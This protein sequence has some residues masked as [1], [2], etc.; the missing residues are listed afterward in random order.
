MKQRTFFVH[1]IGVLL[2]VAFPKIC[3]NQGSGARFSI[4]IST[5]ETNVQS[6]AKVPLNVKLTNTSDREFRI[7]TSIG[8]RAER[9][10]Q[11][12]VIDDHGH[13]A[14]RTAYGD[15]IDGK[16]GLFSGSRGSHL[17]KPGDSLVEN[18][19][20]S[21]IFDPMKPGNYMVRATRTDQLNA[22]V[23]TSNSII[24]TVSQ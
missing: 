6:G 22:V 19:E 13:S 4:T 7:G 9:D 12:D 3:L 14:P 10:F 8:L 21:R 23:V 15:K 16:A 1:A 5:A 2:V 24:L 17:L 20:L 11:I 18:A